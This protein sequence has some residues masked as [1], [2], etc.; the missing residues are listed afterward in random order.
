MW[1]YVPSK[2]HNCIT[3]PLP[4]TSLP[5]CVIRLR[6][7]NG[8]VPYIS[9]HAALTPVWYMLFICLELSTLGLCY[10]TVA[11]GS[12]YQFYFLMIGCSFLTAI[13]CLVVGV[14]LHL[15]RSRIQ[16]LYLFN[17]S[18]VEKSKPSEKV[19]SEKECSCAACPS[20]SDACN[21]TL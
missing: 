12:S 17:S 14:F 20:A 2:E 11:F 19:V 18:F 13:F 9:P 21:S 6:R 8:V 4:I 16:P 15:L 5:F 1:N 3:P 7:L 10:W